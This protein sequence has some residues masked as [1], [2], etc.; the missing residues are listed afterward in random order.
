MNVRLR[1]NERN[2]NKSE[3]YRQFGIRIDPRVQKLSGFL[4]GS[5]HPTDGDG[6][7]PHGP[8][9]DARVANGTVTWF[10][11]PALSP[12]APS[13]GSAPSRPADSGGAER[14]QG[15]SLWCRT[16]PRREYAPSDV[17]CRLAVSVLL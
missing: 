7:R 12:R 11:G 17:R 6:R 1:E 14:S 16:R 3:N 4:E 9:G 2:N 15:W 8:F 10:G 13:G 5:R